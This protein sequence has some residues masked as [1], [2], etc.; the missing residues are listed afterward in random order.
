MS[1]TVK[2]T[3]TGMP[4]AYMRL[5]A[6]LRPHL[7]HAIL[8]LWVFGVFVIGVAYSSWKGAS[9]YNMQLS[10][11]RQLDH[12]AAMHI[13]DAVLPSMSSFADRRNWANAV[14][15]KRA[16]LWNTLCVLLIALTLK[17]TAGGLRGDRLRH[18][19]PL[20]FSSAHVL[21]G[22]KMFLRW[23]VA[24][25]GWG[26]AFTQWCFGPSIFERIIVASGAECLVNSIGVDPAL[27]YART[28]LTTHS[29]PELFK[30]L[31]D[32]LHDYRLT[33]RWH[34]GHDMS[35][36]TFILMLGILLLVEMLVPYLPYA[37]PSFS[38]LRQAIPT[39][40]YAERDIFRTGPRKERTIN[41]VAFW[42]SLLLVGVWT[43]ML[44]ATAV[45][46]HRPYEKVSGL[47]AALFVWLLM[48]KECVLR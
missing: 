8:L 38:L 14:L 39:P 30:Q 33:A 1:R 18:T 23:A 22:S 42:A 34:G 11:V 46:F 17:R 36:H 13:E 26:T 31:P 45:Y 19:V 10:D 40:L 47:Y 28:R 3:D 5:R 24:T 16:W 6:Q 43:A 2:D 21:L 37:L 32:T 4:P 7:Y 35:G 27:C 9:L 44:F 12:V 25:A 29:Y 15:V 41:V 20:S 48:P